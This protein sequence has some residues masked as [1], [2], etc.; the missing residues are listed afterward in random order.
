MKHLTLITLLAASMASAGWWKTYGDENAERGNCVQISSDAN[1]VISGMKGLNLWLLKLDTTGNILW[2]YEY[3]RSDGIR[4]GWMEETEDGGFVIAPR[5]PSL[6]KVDAQGDSLWSR[7]YDI[8]SYCVQET[9]DGGYIVIGGDNGYEADEY[10]MLVRTD[11]DGDTLWTKTYT[12]P[13][14]N[15]NVGSFIQNTADG[16]YIVTGLTGY[17][18]EYEE[19]SNLWLIKIDSDGNRLWSRIYFPSTDTKGYCVRESSDGGYVVTGLG[20]GL[21]GLLIMKT[22]FVGDTIWA[23]TY[24]TSTGGTGFKIQKTNDD[25]YIIVGATTTLTQKTATVAERDL[26]LV[27]TDSLGDTL[28]ARKYPGGG[29]EAIGYC[30]QETADKGFI[31][32]GVLNG[33]LYLLKT[34]SL[35]L[36]AVKEEQPSELEGIWNLE[37]SV[38][39][40]IK[41]HF[42]NVP[43]CTEIT[44]FDATGRKVD[45]L[46]SKASNGSIAWGACQTPGVYFIQAREQ[47]NKRST[48]K[49]VLTH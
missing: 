41:L 13:G 17:A 26:W 16:G 36:L 9:P 3:G 7:N 21:Q 20:P 11:S 19:W 10:L 14:N 6:L 29:N 23:K 43:C 32:T 18:D 1:F 12:E 25:G 4:S 48:V 42:W 30:V 24:S 8:F 39:P 27:K 37:I 49:V 46:Y 34:D 2:E 33:D 40:R 44:I 28:W 35:G 31:V 22:D 45:E 38:G 15:K 5:T 47:K